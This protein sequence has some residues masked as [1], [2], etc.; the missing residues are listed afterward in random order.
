MRERDDID[1]LLYEEMRER[2]LWNVEF[3]A[4]KRR[5]YE[6]LGKMVFGLRGIINSSSMLINVP[7]PFLFCVS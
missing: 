1:F 4:Q 6:L 7:N 2:E 3:A 5:S